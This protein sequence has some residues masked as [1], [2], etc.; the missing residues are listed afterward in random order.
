VSDIKQAVNVE[1]WSGE[2][3]KFRDHDLSLSGVLGAMKG[4]DLNTA[5]EGEFLL[6]FALSQEDV[7]KIIANRP[8]TSKEQL[9]SKKVLSRATY[10]KIRD[11][12][13]VEKKLR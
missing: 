12:V 7:K 13:I 6:L 11:L 5:E 8:Y 1:R 10:L 3:G 9:L 2:P 4:T